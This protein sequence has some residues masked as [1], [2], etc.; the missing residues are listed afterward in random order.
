MW[1]FS[2]E[3]DHVEGNYMGLAKKLATLINATIRGGLPQRRRHRIDA[4]DPHGQLEAI[5]QA[6]AEVERQEQIVADKL[7]ETQLNVEN[8]IA[9]GDQETV[10]AQ[11]NLARKL[12]TQL[13]SQ[14][15]EA[16]TLSEKLAVIEQTIAEQRQEATSTIADA[17]HVLNPANES[18]ADSNPEPTHNQSAKSTTTATTDDDAELAD[19][20][21]R[22][23]G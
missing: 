12:E 3:R 21:S 2:Q 4:D 18:L 19:R 22:L 16:I 17:D 23:S 1:S 8:A 11:R 6:L 20:K 15:T 10:T 7:K 5:R 14:S 9:A 13:E